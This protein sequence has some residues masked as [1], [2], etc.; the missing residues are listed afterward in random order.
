MKHDFWPLTSNQWD[1]MEL[2]AIDRVVRSGQFTMAD[3]TAQFER[4][5]A[6]YHG[7]RHAVMTNS[8]SSANLIAVGSL[9]Y[10]AENPLKRGRVV[11]VPALAWSTTYAPLRQMGLKLQVMDCDLDS[12][13]GFHYVNDEQIVV[14]ILGNPVSSHFRPNLVDN[15]ESLGAECYGVKSGTTGLLNTFSFFHSHQIS[16]IE[17]GMVLTNN[18][19]LYEILLQLRAHGWDRDLNGVSPLYNFVLPGYNVRP[20]EINAAIA[21]EQLKKLPEMICARRK[22]LKIYQELF[23]NSERWRIQKEVGRSSAFAFTFIT[24]FDRSKIFAALDE[25]GIGHRMIT[26]GCFTEHPAAKY[27][28]YEAG[29]LPN[30]M[31]V[32]KQG[33][34]VGN[35]PRDLEEQLVKLKE[36]MEKV[37]Q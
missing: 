24:N 8:G 25:A 21:R 3:E 33:F 10:R 17:G 31:M 28:D 6:D 18:R 29:P 12:L 16:A 22:N 19:E 27:Y 13:M 32:H 37:C 11:I 30:A 23:G 4:E 36:V 7:M 35:Q 26:G 34:F 15:C 14:P 2:C 5:F 9:F 1:H 20:Q